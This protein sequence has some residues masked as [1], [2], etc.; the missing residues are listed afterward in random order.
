MEELLSLIVTKRRL[1]PRYYELALPPSKP[2]S[3]QAQLLPST[4]LH[5]LN[6][7]EIHVI[8]R[9]KPLTDKKHQ[10]A[11]PPPHETKQPSLTKQRSMTLP[12]RAVNQRK[13]SQ[14][15]SFQTQTPPLGQKQTAL[16]SSQKQTPV[17]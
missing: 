14:P 12:G 3:M 5:T 9:S 7:T 2:K 4:A 11:S 1:D 13:T 17:S 6:I 15:S 10:A 8:K 16:P